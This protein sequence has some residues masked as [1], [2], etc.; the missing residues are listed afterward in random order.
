MHDGKLLAFLDL[1]EWALEQM[2]YTA[3]L[4]VSELNFILMLL[5]I[6]YT[7]KLDSFNRITTACFSV[8]EEERMQLVWLLCE[9]FEY[10]YMATAV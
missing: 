10:D 1:S 7:P 6:V 3:L 9:R 5:A 4:L 8:S 2:V